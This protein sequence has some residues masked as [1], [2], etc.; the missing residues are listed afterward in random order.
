VDYGYLKE[1]FC[2][3]LEADYMNTDNMGSYCAMRSDDALYLFFEKSNGIEDWVNN[4]TYRVAVVEREEKWY[5]HEGFLSVWKSILPYIEGLISNKE[6]R[7]IVSVGYS[8][9]AALALLCHEYVWSVRKDI[10]SECEGYGYGCPRVIYGFVPK[11]GERW[12]NFYIIRNIDDMV[13]HLPPRALGYRHVGKLIEIGKRGLYTAVDAH[14][15][16]NY[17]YELDKLTSR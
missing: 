17:I 3:C 5:C 15:E 16:E 1:L 11:E 10:I 7:K 14:R 12:K 9:G 2:L 8:H 6:V 13:T 4:L